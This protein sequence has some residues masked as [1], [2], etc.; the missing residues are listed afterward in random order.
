MSGGL[1][2]F[3]EAV[4]IQPLQLL[5][6]PASIVLII[7][8]SKA[9]WG[10]LIPTRRLASLRRDELRADALERAQSPEQPL[11][12]AFGERLREEDVPAAR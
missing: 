12:L 3:N 7:D 11:L 1:L 4:A 5:G 9:R 6:R 8:V 10:E 2:A